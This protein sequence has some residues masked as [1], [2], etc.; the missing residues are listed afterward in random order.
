MII[1]FMSS[2]NYLIPFAIKFDFGLA[3]HDTIKGIYLSKF[4]GRN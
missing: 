2:A 4:Q 3:S 1:N